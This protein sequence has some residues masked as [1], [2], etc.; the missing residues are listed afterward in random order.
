[1]KPDTEIYVNHHTPQSLVTPKHLEQNPFE[2]VLCPAKS[3][4]TGNAVAEGSLK[5][6]VQ[7]FKELEYY[8]V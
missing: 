4:I 1:M 6:A 2:L 5:L 8:S 3:A 7:F